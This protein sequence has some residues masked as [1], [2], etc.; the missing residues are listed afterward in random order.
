MVTKRLGINL[1]ERC[2]NNTSIR[3]LRILSMLPLY[4]YASMRILE[5]SLTPLR[6]LVPVRL[7]VAR[8]TLVERKGIGAI[9]RRLGPN[10]VGV[11]GLRTPRADGLKLLLKESVVPT[12]ADWARYRIAPRM[13]FTRARLSWSRL[14]LGPALVHSAT[15]MGIRVLRLLSG[16]GVYGIVV[17]GWSSNSK[18]ARLG[19]R[20]TTA[21]ILSY[22]RTRARLRARLVGFGGSF[23]VHGLALSTD[24]AWIGLSGAG[25]I[26]V[27]AS[28][29][30]RNRHPFDLPEAEAELVSGY[31][32]EYAG[33]AF[34]LFFLA[35]YGN[36]RLMAARTTARFQG[37]NTPLLVHLSLILTRLIIYVGARAAYPR[38]RYDQL[39]RLGWKVHFLLARGMLWR[40]EAVLI[41][42]TV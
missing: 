34:A 12:S 4:V 18:Y 31:N 36:C 5:R 14:P 16:L 19:G 27:V 10:T 39:M 9:Q 35:E 26:W 28:R 20:R 6:V 37:F 11:Y 7:G 25:R 24:S 42:I 21:Q 17:A 23:D 30:E 40:H 29:A 38:Y 13:S 3:C 33:M 32:V 15:S 41:L 1:V 8:L 22:E 2:G